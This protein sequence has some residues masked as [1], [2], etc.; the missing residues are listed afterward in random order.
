MPSRSPRASTARAAMRSASGCCS[1]RDG[2]RVD[3]HPADAEADAGRAA[4]VRQGERLRAPVAG[5]HQAVHLHA[6]TEALQDRD[7][8]RGLADGRVPL[9]LQV[10]GGLEH[11]DAALAAGVGRLEHGRQPDLGEGRRARPAASPRRPTAAAARRPRRRP[12]A[13]A[14]C[15]S[16]A[17]RSPC[18][19]PAAR[20]PRRRRRRSGRRDRPR[21]SARRPPGD[22][23][24]RRSRP[25]GRGSRP[26]PR[27]RP[28][29]ARAR[30]RCGRRR[31]RAGRARARAGSR[32]AG[33][34]P[35]RRRARCAWRRTLADASAGAGG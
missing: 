8:G 24:R 9:P 25:R 35:R 22:A 12:A 27:R 20:A 1:T 3:V 21:S 13:S 10:L 29:A 31:R 26:S 34:V 16:C 5:D 17:R 2:R 30:R 19:C 11:D 14:P 32:G 28:P 4:A 33:A 18:R 15:A 6:G 23:P 7:A